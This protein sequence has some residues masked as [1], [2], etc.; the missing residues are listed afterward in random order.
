MSA[1]YLVDHTLSP[2]TLLKSRHLQITFSQNNLQCDRV[3]IIFKFTTLSSLTFFNTT[4]EVVKVNRP[5]GL[6][7]CGLPCVRSYLCVLQLPQGSSPISGR[8]LLRAAQFKFH[9]HSIENWPFFLISLVT[10][11]RKLLHQMKLK[12]RRVHATCEKKIFLSLPGCLSVCFF[13]FCL[14]SPF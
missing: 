4:F 10:R 2:L 6:I 11:R 12:K 1:Y 14:F 3:I 8:S 9:W 13:V 7:I 5:R